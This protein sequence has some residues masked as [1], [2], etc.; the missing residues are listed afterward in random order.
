MQI[1]DAKGGTNTSLCDGDAKPTCMLDTRDKVPECKTWLDPNFIPFQC[2][3]QAA[4]A[5]SGKAQ[6][7]DVFGGT[8]VPDHMGH[9]K[10]CS[11]FCHGKTSAIKISEPCTDNVPEVTEKKTCCPCKKGAAFLQMLS[12]SLVLGSFVG[13]EGAVV[14]KESGKEACCECKK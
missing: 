5:K 12:S 1:C 9:N 7:S 8:T 3:P 13:A 10:F 14:G 11:V 4:W 6:P 2:K